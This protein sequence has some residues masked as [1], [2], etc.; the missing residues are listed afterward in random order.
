MGRMV[1]EERES[2]Y[3]PI[4]ENSI[5]NAS[6][7]PKPLTFRNDRNTK[8][9]MAASSIFTHNHG[10]NMNNSSWQASQKAIINVGIDKISVEFGKQGQ[11]ESGPEGNKETGEER[12][13]R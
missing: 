12:R 4:K 6:Q 1:S 5:H 10:Q 13:K 11:G 7:Q 3:C 2:D 9:K 8:S